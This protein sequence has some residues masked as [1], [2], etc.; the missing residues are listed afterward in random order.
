MTTIRLDATGQDYDRD[1]DEFISRLDVGDSIEFDNIKSKAYLRG[2]TACIAGALCEDED[3]SIENNSP[4][5]FRQVTDEK[6]LTYVLTR[7]E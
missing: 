5:K 7:V 4:P 2:L 1:V 3:D 6:D